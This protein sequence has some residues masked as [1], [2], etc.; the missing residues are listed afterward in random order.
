[1]TARHLIPLLAGSAIVLAN[2]AFGADDDT[3]QRGAYLARAGDCVACHT[4]PGGKPFAGGLPIES[5]FGTIYSTNI[6]PDKKAG[7]GNYSEAEFAAALRQG[8]RAD[9]ANLYPA[10]PYPSYAKLTDDDV[11]ALYVY[12]M[13]SVKPV[14]E[15]PPETDLGFPFNQRWGISA[16]NWLFADADTFQ[17]NAS[18]DQLT[19]RGRY[20]VEGLGHCGSCHTPR[21]FAEQEKALDGDSE[22]YLAGANLNGWWAPS[23]RGGDDGDGRGIEGWDSQAIVDYLKTGRNA[24]ATV[25]GE[26]T[27]VVA[28]STTHLTDKDLM[29]IAQYLKSLSANPAGDGAT[30]AD[31]RQQATDETAAHLQAAKNLSDGERLYIDNCAACHLDDGNGAERV[32]PPINGNS[33][34][35]ADDPTGLIHTILAGAKPPAT[36]TIPAQLPMPGFGWRLSDDEVATLATFVRGAWGNDGGAVTADQVAKVR[37]SIDDAPLDKAVDP[38]GELNHDDGE[39]H[40]ANGAQ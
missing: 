40:A 13:Q 7:I 39:S 3:V 2:Q 28:N 17:P 11:H 26:M 31:Q 32:F 10:M 4:A 14:A 16:W 12:F 19:D 23:L 36:P 22:D 25:G 15:Q 20:L 33:L 8:E 6:T 38:N 34:A 37:A 21:G 1:M 5:P 35:N 24:H 29:G 18:Y 9:G 27:S 30:T